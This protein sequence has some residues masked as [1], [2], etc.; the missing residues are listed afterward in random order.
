MTELSRRTRIC[1]QTPP[2]VTGLDF[3]QVVDHTTQDV[4]RL[5]FL[6]N[7]RDVVDPDNLATRRFPNANT[8]TDL[9]A[10]ALERLSI[11]AKETG[12]EIDV[13]SATWIDADFNGD[14]RQALEITVDEPGSA[15]IFTLTFDHTFVDRFFDEVDFSFKQACPTGTDCKTDCDCPDEDAPA[16][17]I[18]Y[19]ARDFTSLRGALLDFAAQY[20]GEWEARVEADQAMMVLEI[21]AHLGDEL[22]YTQDR[23]AAE[24][25]L[26]TATQRKSVAQLARLVDYEIDHGEAAQ[27]ELAVSVNVGTT[28]RA[29]TGVDGGLPAR[30]FALREDTGAIPFEATEDLWAHPDWNTVDLYLPDSASPCLPIGA[31]SACLQ[32]DVPTALQTPVGTL[33][34]A[35][36]WEGR[37]MIL[38]S[39]LNAPDE[40]NRAW[41][42]TISRTEPYDDLLAPAGTELCEVFWDKAEALPF[43]MPIHEATAH[44]N[45][46]RFVAGETV[47]QSFRVGD[48]TA[49]MAGFVG[50]D[51]AQTRKLTDL[52]RASEREGACAAGGRGVI[53]RFGLT[54]SDDTGV[55]WAPSAGGQEPHMALY[56]VVPDLTTPNEVTFATPIGAQE[57][58]FVETTLR[59]DAEDRQ[60]TLEHGLWSE[61]ARFHRPEGDVVL[62]D[63][64]SNSGFTIR[65]GDRDFGVSPPEGTVFHLRYLTAPGVAANLPADSVTHTSLPETP[66]PTPEITAV[67]NPFPIRN[68]RAPETADT[69]RLNAP[70]A[71]RAILK[72]A[73]QS[74]DYRTILERRDDV[75]QANATARWTGTWTTD[76]AA[77]DPL[78]SQTLTDNM[79]NSVRAELDCVRMAGRQVCLRDPMAVPIDIEIDVCAQPQATNA[80][81]QRAIT[82]RLTRGADAFFHPDNFTFG[83]PLLRSTLETAVQ[84]VPGV[85][86]VES[87]L[88][89][90]RG[91]GSFEPMPSRLTVAPHQILQ[92]ANDAARPERGTLAVSTHGGG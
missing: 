8:G 39:G 38:R 9:T 50:A 19:L 65:F 66:P 85:R 84:C 64:A 28:L 86:A 23:Y 89:R 88:I 12:E 17:A 41:A 13:A 59:G 10:T 76:F 62:D 6:V 47:T 54:G 15:A 32:I 2:P 36:F 61:V 16:V 60:F 25:Y 69:V 87:I 29:A 81:L 70:E 1:L 55:A 48:D 73:V 45:T 91:R 14:Q 3:V 18:D 11:V 49:L 74:A 82:R 58:A 53:L 27:T 30:A 67:T 92:L 21:L 56:E 72:R 63:Y 20:Y 34:P 79:R 4:L 77:V 24:A 78:G 80:K 46:C 22:A 57:W 5:F 31:T 52:P 42:V 40:P 33:T 51:A 37:R 83:T 71:F 75:Q 68:A 26:K 90:R 43:E 35:R 7:P 44:L